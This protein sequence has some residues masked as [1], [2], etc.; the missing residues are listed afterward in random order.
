MPTVALIRP[1]YKGDES[2]FQEPLGIERLAVF[3]EAHGI[4]TLQFDR[5][6]FEREGSHGFW[7]EFEPAVPDLVGLS[8]MTAEDVPDALRVI[9][10]IRARRPFMRFVVGGLYVTTSPDAARRRFPADAVLVQNE[11]EL[12]LLGLVS[13]DSGGGG[14][15]GGVGG[16]GPGLSPDGW[17]CALRPHF[18]RYLRLGCAISL[19]SARGCH[20]NCSFCATPTMPAPYRSWQGRPTALVASEMETLAARARASGLLPIFNFVDDDFGSLG[21]IEQLDL[22]LRR[23]GLRVAYALQLR[24]AALLG[25]KRLDSRLAALKAGGLTR[26][27]LGVES[28]CPQTLRAWGKPYDIDGAPPVFEAL[29]TAGISAHIGYIL[30]HGKSTIEGARAEAQRLWELGLY[31]PK[32]AEGRMVLFPG[33]RLH[34]QSQTGGTQDLLARWEPL[35]PP[36]E[37]FYHDVSSRQ[38]PVYDVWKEAAVLSPWLAARAHLTGDPTALDA[39][40]SIL[41]ACDRYSFEGLMR[42]EFPEDLPKIAASLM[43]KVESIRSSALGGAFGGG[44]GDGLGGG[45]SG[46]LGDGL[47]GEPGGGLGGGRSSALGGGRSGALT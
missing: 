41:A 4:E 40:N 36:V 3:L 29:R 24:M 15:V 12:P 21:R 39:L 23:R 9:S 32:V 10:R 6:L 7:E 38:Q 11:G 17:A 30:W 28:L 5:R 1:L 47:G 46:A 42:N 14:G 22:E 19:Q 34:H 26:V 2:E 13:P 45:Q 33:S 16:G 31:T 44:F 35:D 27:F 37:R 18:E 43:E 25:Q 20:G 8:V